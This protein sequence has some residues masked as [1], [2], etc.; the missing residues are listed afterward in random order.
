MSLLL[1]PL[2]LRLVA[3]C[4]SSSQ[5]LRIHAVCPRYDLAR[6]VR[7]SVSS[8]PPLFLPSSRRFD[9]PIRLTV[10]HDSLTRWI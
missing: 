5:V 10:L 1:L 2:R 7:S 6:R 4:S 3:F 8:A 9:R